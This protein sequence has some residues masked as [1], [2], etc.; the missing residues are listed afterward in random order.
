MSEL[1]SAIPTRTPIKLWLPPEP[2]A[3]PTIAL[4]P[5]TLTSGPESG[6][7]NQIYALVGY[8]ILAKA[9]RLP[10]VLPSCR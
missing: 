1:S 5:H 10:L 3:A 4:M 7:C 2:K 9:K 8:A 6:L